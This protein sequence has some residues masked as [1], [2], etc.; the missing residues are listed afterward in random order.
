MSEQEPAEEQPVETTDETGTEYDFFDFV[1]S[2][3][4]LAGDKE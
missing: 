1:D 4:A 2:L 3:Y